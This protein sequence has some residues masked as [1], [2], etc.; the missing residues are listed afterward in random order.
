MK[1]R[2]Q[3]FCPI[4]ETLPKY[5]LSYCNGGLHSDGF[6]RN[7]QSTTVKICHLPPP[8]SPTQPECWHWHCCPTSPPWPEE[9]HPAYSELEPFLE[10]Y[11]KGH[12]GN[13]WSFPSCHHTAAAAAQLLNSQDAGMGTT[14]CQLHRH[15]TKKASCGHTHWVPH[16]QKGLVTHSTSVGGG[17]T[18]GQ[19]WQ[20][21]RA[22][23]LEIACFLEG[24]RESFNM[25]KRFRYLLPLNFLNI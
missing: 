25:P 2:I 19:G 16:R 22:T 24:K 8:W 6:P 10:L 18:A 12:L 9:N 15:Q 17:P 21:F 5:F 4:P 13:T 1:S 11:S 20:P 3:A 23:T 14:P 7:N